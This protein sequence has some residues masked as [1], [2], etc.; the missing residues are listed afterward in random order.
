MILHKKP[1]GCPLNLER[2]QVEATEKGVRGGAI[3]GCILALSSK[4]HTLLQTSTDLCV[5]VSHGI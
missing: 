1:G 2:A 5:H 3:F 4:S